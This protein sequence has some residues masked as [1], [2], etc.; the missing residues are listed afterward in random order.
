MDENTDITCD[1][2]E[3]FI[4]SLDCHALGIKRGGK[5]GV[6]EPLPRFSRG[7]YKLQR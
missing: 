6:E 7:I 1:D 4:N 3:G 5:E 2:A